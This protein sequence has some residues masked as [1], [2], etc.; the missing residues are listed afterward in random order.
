MNFFCKILGCEYLFNFPSIPNKCICKRCKKKWELNLKSLRW[1]EVEK[2]D[3]ELGTDE[4]LI[5]R[6]HC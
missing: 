6:W 5:I 3:P 1:V 4:E 2:F